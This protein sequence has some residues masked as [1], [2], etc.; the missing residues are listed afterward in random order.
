[1]ICPQCKEQGKKS[2]IEVEDPAMIE[3]FDEDGRW[4]LFNKAAGSGGENDDKTACRCSRGHIFIVTDAQ[5]ADECRRTNLGDPG[6]ARSTPRKYDP[7][8]Y[9]PDQDLP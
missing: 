3:W 4:H 9:H 5:L 8:G 6:V 2:T 7:D 1:M